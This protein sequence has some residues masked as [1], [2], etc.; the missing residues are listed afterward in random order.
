MTPEVIAKLGMD[1]I[2]KDKASELQVQLH[3]DGSCFITDT[4]GYPY[5][6]VR[7]AAWTRE[8]AD[9]LAK[10]LQDQGFKVTVVECAKIES[11]VSTYRRL[12]GLGASLVERASG[13][14]SGALKVLS[15][16]FSTEVS[17][18]DVPFIRYRVFEGTVELEDTVKRL[19]GILTSVDSNEMA[20][21]TLVGFLKKNGAKALG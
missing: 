10:V 20:P 16:A 8:Q 21:S 13:S 9:M 6:G 15:D 4:E 19:G 5:S 7:R 11:V 12:V 18:E 2:L 1:L 14:T 3:P 17:L